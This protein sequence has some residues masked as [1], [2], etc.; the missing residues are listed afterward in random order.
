VKNLKSILLVLFI[1]FCCGW[2]SFGQMNLTLTLNRNLDTGKIKVFLIDGA[3]KKFLSLKFIERAALVKENIKS[4]YARLIFM[5]PSKVGD[6]LGTCF[7]V[8]NEKSSVYFDRVEENTIDMLS[9]YSSQNIIDVKDAQVFNKINKYSY[10]ELKDFNRIN[11]EKINRKDSF[12]KLLETSYE[13]LA[14]KQIDF[15]KKNGNQYLYFEKFINEI[16]PSLKSK[17][18]Q[19]LYEVFNTS[20][21]KNFTE[22]YEGQCAKSL[23]EGNLFIKVGMQSPQF[24]TFDY[25]SN[26]VSS[27][28][29]KGRYFLLSFWATWCGPCLKEIPQLQDIRNRYSSEK[30]EIISISR[31]TDSIRFVK[32]IQNY[33]M[34]WIHVFNKPAMENLFGEK[35]IPSLYLMDKDGKIVFSSWEL[36]LNELDKILFKGMDE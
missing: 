35:P 18:L 10:R 14:S 28:K 32:G 9:N 12:L 16:V 25:L 22:S 24:K 17:H 11:E 7:L 1:C 4:K 26:E 29:F 13:K 5:Y 8:N 34:N 6:I 36:P 20:F 15:I 21:P 27:E 2:K 33:K 3:V 31:D 19:K 23:L 30:L